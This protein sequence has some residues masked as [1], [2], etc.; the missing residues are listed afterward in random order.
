VIDVGSNSVLLLVA[1][2]IDGRWESVLETS[3]VTGL[4]TGTKET[5]L[6]SEEPMERT[7]AAVKKGFDEARAAGAEAILAAATMAA[8]IARNTDEFQ[9]RALAQGTPIEVLSGERE[10]EL[11]FRSVALDPLFDDAGRLSIIDVG[12]HSTEVA[13]ADHRDT[14]WAIAFRRSFPI[15]TLGLRGRTLSEESPSIEARMRA[16]TEIDAALGFSFRPGESGLSVALGASATN[17]VTLREGMTEWDPVRVHGAFLDY[18]EISRA[19]GWLSDMTDALRGALVGLEK[20]REGTIH[21]GALI[22]ERCLFALRSEGCKVSVRGW[23][24]ALLEEL[25]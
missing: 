22:L 1:E 2:R 18:E 11:G 13:C 20:G 19:A 4:G 14:G 23:R 16:V 12:G 25:E 3:T 21:I 5:R 9:A 17:L 15:G 8:R 10:A 24:H 7:L 6:L